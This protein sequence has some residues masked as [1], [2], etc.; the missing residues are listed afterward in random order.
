LCKRKWKWAK[1][2]ELGKVTPIA[3]VREAIQAM[4]VQPASN[5]TGPMNWG[6]WCQVRVMEILSQR[7]VDTPYRHPYELAVHHAAM[8]EVLGKVLR[9]PSDRPL[10]HPPSVAPDWS[11]QPLALTD[12]DGLRLYRVVLTDR[13]DDDRQLRELHSWRTLGDI[14]VT[15]LPMTIKVVVLGPQRNGYRHGPWTQ[16]RQHPRN[17]GL[18]WR[19]K[20]GDGEGFSEIW[21]RVWREQAKVDAQSWV[22]GMQR[23]GVLRE[24]VIERHVKVPAR[25]HVERVLEDIRRTAEQMEMAEKSK[26]LPMMSRSACDFPVPCQFQRCCYSELELTPGD[27]P[28][29]QERR[30]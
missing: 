17:K 23:D 21:E 4:L 29:F 5:P 30:K 11:W 13:W 3:A 1:E 22:E 27:L 24:A 7:G 14:C 10:R 19:R 2:W 8:A 6:K 20:H 12:D 15:G 28:I 26:V 16:A 9:K 25:V 18:R